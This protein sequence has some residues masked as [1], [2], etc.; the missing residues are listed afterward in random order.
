MQIDDRGPQVKQ[1]HSALTKYL[2]GRFSP[3][4][5]ILENMMLTVTEWPVYYN[6]GLG[7]LRLGRP[8]RAQPLLERSLQL[9]LPA[10]FREGCIDARLL[11]GDRD[12]ALRHADVLESAPHRAMYRAVAGEA[13]ADWESLR[14]AKAR[15]FR[16]EKPRLRIAYFMTAT[17]LCG[18]SKVIFEHAERLAG[19]GHDVAIISFDAAPDWHTVRLPFY[20]SNF[21]LSGVRDLPR[22]DIAVSGFFWINM[23][24][25][26]LGNRTYHFAQ[27][28]EW[29]FGYD[30]FDALTK[31]AVWQFHNLPNRQI[32]VSTFLAQAIDNHFERPQH[33]LIPV[34]IEDFFEPGP[35]KNSG[36]VLMIGAEMNRFKNV[37]MM[38]QALDIL[39]AR[40]Y[41]LKVVWISSAP[42]QNADF[43]CD[44]HHSPER[45]LIAQLYRTSEVFVSA[46]D[47]EASPLPILEAMKS[48]TAIVTS[49]SGGIRDYVVNGENALVVSPHTAEALAG[50]I[51]RL[52]DDGAL[53]DALARNGRETSR[54]FSWDFSMKKLQD[55]LYEDL[56]VPF[57]AIP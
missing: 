1:F 49:D 44:F 15:W 16:D 47:F 38:M 42:R 4:V 48:G 30:T 21:A 6:A 55:M 34:S 41:P 29:T 5:A 14:A 40:G 25:L 31:D 46:S 39:R 43:A 45:R 20:Q 3:S 37:P 57:P 26:L 11:L 50:A 19:M 23:L 22:F 2:D 27:G 36:Q 18:G 56:A 24:I 13:F 35:V 51:A 33:T 7:Y 52:L 9:G 8:D 17:N 53:R 10:R 54:R 12:A 32:A 28:D